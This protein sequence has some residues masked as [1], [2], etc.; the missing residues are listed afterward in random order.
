MPIY[1]Y[2]CVD[3]ADRDQ[4]VAGL[5]DHISLCTRCGGLMLRLEKDAF[6][7]YFEEIS[8]HVLSHFKTPKVT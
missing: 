7:S 3:C 6:W 5:N 4:R 2:Q 8:P 1:E